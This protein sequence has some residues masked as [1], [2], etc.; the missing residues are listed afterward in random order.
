ME[1]QPNLPANL[2]ARFDARRLAANLEALG[3]VD[4]ALA[5]RLS[6]PCG[7]DHVGFG[8]DGALVLHWRR[9][10]LRI[11]LPKGEGRS[12][13]RRAA[14]DDSSTGWLF[15]LG[16]GEPIE[17]ALAAE[18]ARPWIAWERDP[19]LLRLTLARL[20]LTA[21]IASGRLKLAL[22]TDLLAFVGRSD[23]APGGPIH[24]HPTLGQVYSRELQLLEAGADS[25]D[26]L[27]AEGGLFVDQL[28]AALVRRGH[29]VFTVDL[30][31]LSL[32]ELSHGV[33]QSGARKLFAINYT[34]GLAEFAAEAGL[35][36]FVWEIDPSLDELRPLAG[37][38]ERTRI[39]TYRASHVA[40]FQ[41]SGF[42]HVQHLPLAADA[43]LRQP[44]AL[45]GAEK[46][47]YGVPLA[48]VGSSMVAEAGQYRAAFLDLCAAVR[49]ETN[50]AAESTRLDALLERQR[51]RPNSY[52]LADWI[53]R[54][55]G[56][57]LQAA[58]AAAPGSNPVRLLADVAAADKRLVLVGALGSRGIHVWG[59]SGW[60]LLGEFGVHYR[61]PAGHQRELN[62]IYSGGGIQLDVNRIY[63]PDIVT[64]RVFDVLACGGFCLTEHSRELDA[65]F[66]VGVELDSY[67]G[68]E[69][70][71]AKVDHYLAHPDEARAIAARGLAAV[72][73]RHTIDLRLDTMLR[74][75]VSALSAA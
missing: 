36:L 73:K 52:Q 17:A 68:P 25:A 56:D 11:D 50:R 8:P 54:V 23:G 38:S 61:G 66:D 34:H 46:Q 14:A 6:W 30:E 48:F 26:V 27:L 35:E 15:G 5:R 59:D 72:K 49:G 20:D 31:R 47:R 37:S 41:S 69:E 42:E 43:H 28:G 3:K 7:S 13:P 33:R 44:V 74:A 12:A 4:R 51:A 65:L 64:M 70:L 18:P 40:G 19:W 57:V 1:S 55:Y 63:Q 71:I 32:E 22:G 21:A 2:P 39:F 58:R 9:T 67:R 62:R 45:E 75:Q 16:Q 24:V 10:P 60:D 29:S 53:E